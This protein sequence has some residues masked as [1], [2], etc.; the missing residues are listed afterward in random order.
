MVSLHDSRQHFKQD[1]RPQTGPNNILFMKPTIRSLLLGSMHYVDRCTCLQIVNNQL[2]TVTME[3]NSI[4]A[5]P[6]LWGNLWA[7]IEQSLWRINGI[8]LLLSGQKAFQSPHFKFPWQR[9]SNFKT[10][11]SFQ[12][13]WS[14][15]LQIEPYMKFLGPMVEPGERL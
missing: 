14:E 1:K 5:I 12:T 11:L 15:A 3:T 6:R 2:F 9:N 7:N 4:C 8:N 10:L 13:S